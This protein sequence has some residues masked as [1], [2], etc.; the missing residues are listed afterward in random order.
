MQESQ[1]NVRIEYIPPPSEHIE[2]YGRQ[3]CRRLG[4]EF[5][6]PEIIHGFTQFVKV[7]VQII[8]RRLNGEGF[9]NASDQG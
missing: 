9:D 8:E 5:A 3:V 4:E 6:E 7:A 2:D 1:D